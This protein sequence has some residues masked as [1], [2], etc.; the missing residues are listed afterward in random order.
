VGG[1]TP[2]GCLQTRMMKGRPDPEVLKDYLAGSAGRR[3]LEAMEY[4]R[5]YP[6]NLAEL[7]TALPHIRTPVLSIWGAHDP[8]APPPNADVLDKGL[9]KTR[10]VL[11]DSGHFVWED[12]AEQYAAAVLDWIRGGYRDV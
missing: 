4:V 12:Q 9:P 7:R 1:E 3:F 10:S 11:L 2:L 6:T 5:A 8:I